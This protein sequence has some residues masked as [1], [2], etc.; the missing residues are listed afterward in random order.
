V[1]HRDLKP[2]NLLLRRPGAEIVLGDFGVANLGHLGQDAKREAVGTLAYMAPE[3]RRGAAEPASDV[4]SA[5]VILAEMLTGRA[6]APLS[7][8]APQLPPDLL[9]PPL[10]PAVAAHLAALTAERPADRPTAAAAALVAR[11]LLEMVE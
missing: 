2:A 9:A 11:D 10:G 4:W 6:P 7:V 3:Q 1:V 5:G 8:A